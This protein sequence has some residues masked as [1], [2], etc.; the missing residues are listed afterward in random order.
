MTDNDEWDDDDYSWDEPGD[1]PCDLEMWISAYE[2]YGWATTENDLDYSSSYIDDLT[3]YVRMVAEFHTARHFELLPGHFRWY[4][5][6]IA[7]LARDESP[8]K[9][10]AGVAHPSGHT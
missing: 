8:A 1:C 7:E 3:L 5:R 2:T 6:T 4:D 9:A 10:L